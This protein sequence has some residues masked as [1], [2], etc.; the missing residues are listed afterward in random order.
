MVSRSVFEDYLGSVEAARI[1][2]IHPRSLL[3]LV[4]RK[5]VI[6]QLFAGKYLFHRDEVY[7]FKESYD[8]KQGGKTIWKLL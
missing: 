5:K 8:P 7:R 6:A 2:G 4:R 3:R 1:L